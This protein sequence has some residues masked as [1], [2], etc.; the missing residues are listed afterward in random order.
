MDPYRV[1]AWDAASR[2]PDADGTGRRLPMWLHYRVDLFPYFPG[3]VTGIRS[4]AGR[5]LSF[6]EAFRQ[7]RTGEPKGIVQIVK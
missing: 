2:R 5:A 7:R 6:P 3:L 4:A 1:W